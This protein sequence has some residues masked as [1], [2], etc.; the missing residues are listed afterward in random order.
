MGQFVFGAGT[1]LA[2][3]T[4]GGT[5]QQFGTLQDI[6]VDFSFTNKELTG[7]YQLPVAIGRGPAKVSGKAKAASFSANFFNQVFFGQTPIA[8][9]TNMAVNEAHT[10][11]STPFQVT[12]AP[13]SGGTFLDDGGVVNATT[14]AVLVKVASGPISGQYAA[15]A[16]GV[17]TFA[18]SDVGLQALFTY[19]YTQAANGFSAILANQLMGSAPVFKLVLNNVYQGNQLTLELYQSISDKLSL[20]FKNTDWSIPEFDFSCFTNSANNLGKLSVT[21][22]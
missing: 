21:Q 6:S 10:V 11:P 16:G 20:D 12:I 18:S 15:S 3:P 8:G 1:V 13:P 2:L 17:Y 9:V 7:Q 14:G 22:F 5:P 19:T 4:G